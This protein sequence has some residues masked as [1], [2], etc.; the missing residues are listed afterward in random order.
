MSQQTSGALT[1][2]NSAQQ[3]RL[4][5]PNIF[6]I[7][8]SHVAAI[9]AFWY[10][11]WT[12]FWL[13]MAGVFLIAPIGVNL[14]F[15]RVLT[16]R[17][18]KLPKWLEYIVVTVGASIGG[19]PPLHWVA[20]HR[21]HHRFSD[22]PNDP[23]NSREGFWHSH[24]THLFYHKDFEDIEEQW[25]RYV[26]DLRD[27][28]YYRFLN[29]NWLFFTVGITVPLY[30]IGGISY[31]LWVGFM[32]ALLMLHITWFV[33]SAS[34]MWG[35]QNYKTKDASTNCWW[36]GI[37]AAGEGWH[38]N[39]HAFPTSAKHGH[40]WWEFDF[41]YMII[42]TLEKLGLAKDVKIP[43]HLLDQKS[44]GGPIE[45]ESESSY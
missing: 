31:V 28:K 40:K 37:L 7:T 42:W 25:L 20:E 33:N 27:D 17:S 19:G 26:P 29:K 43:A 3:K 30:F 15:H 45:L 23:H 24:I 32:R 14:A 22:T 2:P 11:D 12:A 13:C 38:N 10:F 6:W 5:I 35:Y 41:T 8:A 18:L 1:P 9:A 21:L 39:H 44:K 4:H 16:H 36:V 34:H